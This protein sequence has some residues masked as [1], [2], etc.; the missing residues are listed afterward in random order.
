M[1]F[2]SRVQLFLQNDNTFYQ[3]LLMGLLIASPSLHYLCFDNTYDPLSLRIFNSA[4]CLVAIGIT[5]FPAKAI[6]TISHYVVVIG[7][8]AINNCVL[9]AA[10]GFDH[11]YLF[12][13]ITIFIALTLFCTKRWEFVAICVLNLTGTLIAYATAGQL[14]ISVPALVVLLLT[15]T[16]IAY[17]SFLVMM[18]YKLKFNKAVD[19]VIELNRDLTANDEKLNANRKMLTSL[20]NSLNDIIFEFDEDKICLNVWFSEIEGRVIDPAVCLGKRISDILGAEKAKK[21]DDAIF[22]NVAAAQ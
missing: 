5:F 3:L 8:L 11:V 13:A 2:K 20:I 21:F 14:H 7:F 19:S 1:S 22:G 6:Q 10:N 17:V 18:S 15:F 16:C 4:L 9:L 12:S